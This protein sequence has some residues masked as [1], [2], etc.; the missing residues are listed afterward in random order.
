MPEEHGRVGEE[1]RAQSQRQRAGQR[2]LRRHPAPGQQQEQQHDAGRAGGHAGEQVA[3]VH[4]AQEGG[5]EHHRPVLTGRGN[6][7]AVPVRLRP[8][9][10]R[11]EHPLRARGPAQL[12]PR[13]VAGVGGRRQQRR[14]GRLVAVPVA[15]QV[16]LVLGVR[17]VGID[18]HRLALDQRPHQI[19][20]GDLVPGGLGQEI[21]VAGREQQP[22]PPG[23]PAQGT[24]RGRAPR[25]VRF[26][27]VPWGW[28]GAGAR[29]ASAP[30]RRSS[31]TS[32]TAPPA[33]RRTRSGPRRP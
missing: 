15:A 30:R 25:R 14:P 8:A 16:G 2:P 24:Q 3:D 26:S 18:V 9:Q 31:R 10:L 22:Q 33:D 4:R 1:R 21:G 23:G 13:Q 28:P 27:H 17:V 20:P 19:E 7:S 5:V 6:R 32:S 29:P 12:R 11:L